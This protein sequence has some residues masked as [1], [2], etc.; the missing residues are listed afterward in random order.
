M[1]DEVAPIYKLLESQVKLFRYEAIGY[2]GV[3][4]AFVQGLIM[5]KVLRIILTIIM[6]TDQRGTTEI[7]AK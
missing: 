1:L 6:R 3:L 4:K 5:L 2:L 7:S